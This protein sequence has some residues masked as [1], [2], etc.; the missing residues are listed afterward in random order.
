[1]NKGMLVGAGVLA[2]SA[3]GVAVKVA[4]PPQQVQKPVVNKS[5]VDVFKQNKAAADAQKAKK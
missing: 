1:M 2:V 3:V 5:M 4:K